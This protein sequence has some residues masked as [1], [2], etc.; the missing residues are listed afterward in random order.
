MNILPTKPITEDQYDKL[1]N[2]LWVIEQRLEASERASCNAV[3]HDM[4]FEK[5]ATIQNTLEAIKKRL[6]SLEKATNLLLTAE[7]LRA[8]RK[9]LSIKPK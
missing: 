3:D 1:M 8:E 9:L 4:L 7:N 5:Q 6:N 2:K